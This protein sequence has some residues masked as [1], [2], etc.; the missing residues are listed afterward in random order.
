VIT[1]LTASAMLDI[2]ASAQE[3]QNVSSD[4]QGSSPGATAYTR[5]DR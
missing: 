3:T 5:R 2:T 1:G 4:Y